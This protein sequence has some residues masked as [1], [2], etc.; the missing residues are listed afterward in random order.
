M[1]I[2]E[3]GKEYA[4]KKTAAQMNVNKLMRE[5]REEAGLSIRAL[6]KLIG[7]S[8]AFLSDMESGNRR[9]SEAWCAL[10][11]EEIEYC[12]PEK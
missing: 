1:E 7:C 4:R 2:E 12:K 10:A 9:Y 3:A 11:I 6:S 5:Q 8:A